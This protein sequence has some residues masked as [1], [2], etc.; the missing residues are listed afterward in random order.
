MS[1]QAT[2]PPTTESATSVRAAFDLCV[3]KTRRNLSDLA[4][5]RRTWAFAV[6]GDYSASNEGFFEIGNWTTS[7]FT[8]MGM[9][10][11]LDNG[12]DEI[13]SELGLSELNY[14]S[15]MEGE[16]ASETM[17]DL[18]FLY[19]LYSVALY[20]ATGESRHRTLG[21][22]AAET[23]AARFIPAG[24]YIRAWGRMD[25]TSSEYAGLAIIDCMMNLPLL[26]WASEQTGDP[27]FK[28][29]A[30]RHSDTTLHR[31]IRSDDSVYHAYRFDEWGKPAGGDN[32]C[33]NF[34]ESDWAR[35]SAWAMYGFA[36]G[37][38]HTREERHLDASLRICRKFVSKLDEEIIP[39]WDFRLPPDAPQI[40]DSSAAAIAVCAIQELESLGKSESA[41]TQAKDALLTRLLEP[42]YLDRNP[43][44]R[45]ILKQGQ[46]GDGVG[47]ARNAYTSW[48]D[49]FLMEAFARELGIKVSWW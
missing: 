27:R 2:A 42:D 31:F 19:S 39:I 45:G 23:L 1:A 25:D 24:N 36:L 35:G 12:D 33:G 47:K 44:C 40:R 28:A 20:K 32:Y 46:I 17:H 48:G 6:D 22:R 11:W 30:I 49:Y 9:L 34:V 7:F 10:A 4:R 38:R 14:L 21:L 13:L 43:A 41:L 5:S 3:A 37:Y 8:G 15:K 29:I 26:Y 18:G 16:N